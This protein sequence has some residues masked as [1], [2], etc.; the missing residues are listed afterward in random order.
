MDDG[1]RNS[2]DIEVQ[3]GMRFGGFES[4]AFVRMSSS[5]TSSVG[6]AFILV[7]PSAC[8]LKA[9]RMRSRSLLGAPWRRCDFVDS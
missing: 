7:R 4:F 6:C 8:R 2:A 9:E 3:S 1:V 5:A